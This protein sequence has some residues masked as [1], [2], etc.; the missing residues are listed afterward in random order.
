MRNELLSILIIAA[1]LFFGEREIDP[2]PQ[3]TP[4]PS[5]VEGVAE[6]AETAVIDY[7][8]GLAKVYEQAANEQ[9]EGPWIV[10]Q[11]KQARLD[12]FRPLNEA[13]ESE[14]SAE[15]LRQA[16]AGA[17]RAVAKSPEGDDLFGGFGQ[18]LGGSR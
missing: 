14:F 7:A 15:R 2:G 5:P 16:A 13:M 3:P 6:L 17:R 8:N 4:D 9:Q 1:L 12:A 10:E 11:T 18:S